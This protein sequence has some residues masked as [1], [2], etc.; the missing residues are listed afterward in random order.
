MCTC[1][2]LR[3]G[4]F[5]VLKHRVYRCRT[6]SMAKIE[7]GSDTSLCQE[8]GENGSL[9]R[10]RWEWRMLWKIMWQFVF[11]KTTAVR[12]HSPT[13]TVLAVSHKSRRMELRPCV[14]CSRPTGC[15][16]VIYRKRSRNL[17][18]HRNLYLSVH[19]NFICSSPKLDPPRHPLA[20]ELLNRLVRP[21]HETLQ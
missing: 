19:T 9:V 6:V 21:R 11:K 12:C 3:C 10:C 7:S 4:N 16:S 17:C 8:C 14:S 5:S 15:P 18:S 2:C 20:D 13:S 1:F